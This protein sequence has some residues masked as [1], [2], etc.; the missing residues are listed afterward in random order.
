MISEQDF[1]EIR[2]I[3][4]YLRKVP[5]DVTRKALYSARELYARSGF[6]ADSPE[7]TSF[8]AE[9]YAHFLQTG[10]QAELVEERLARALHDHGIQAALDRFFKT[11]HH[12]LCLGIMGG[13]ALQR[14]DTMFRDIVSLS[15]RLTEN[16]F[17]MLSG[18]G[19][20][21]MEA[22]HLG[23]WMA[24][25]S[26]EEVSD[27][28]SLLRE[29]PTFKDGGWL[30]TAF[31]VIERYPQES[32][33]SLGIPTWLYGHEP[34]T[35]FA[36]HIAKFFENSI[37]EDSILTLAYGGVVYTPGSAGTM[38]EIFQDAVQNHYLSFGFSSPM[39]FLGKRFWTEEMPIYPLLEQLASM[40]KYKNLRLTLT[41]DLDEIVDVLQRFR[42]ELNDQSLKALS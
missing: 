34:S 25:R 38:Q 31:A 4:A 22:T 14:T 42:S 2:D 18:G 5:Y 1:D 20:G 12:H 36:T 8:D 23:A 40:G 16:G 17:Y 15:K 11:H 35:P 6:S 26:D 10:K 3:I 27:A 29:A 19:P 41:D 30:S 39:V 28:L 24:G 32:Y 7:G 13:H 37:R 33:E 9:V 21:A